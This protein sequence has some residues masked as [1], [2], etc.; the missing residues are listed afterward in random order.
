[1]NTLYLVRHGENRANITKEFSHTKVDYPLT[2]KGVLQARQTAEYF[3]D[4]HVDEIYS[5]PLKRALQTAEMIAATKGL[6][7]TVI[8]SLREVNSGSLEDTPP[9]E[10]NWRIYLDTVQGWNEGRPEVALPGGENYYMLVD[11]IKQAIGEIVGDKDGKHIVV[12]GHGGIFT[13]AIGWL[14]KN[15]EADELRSAHYHNCA[16]SQIELE[17]S[18]E[19]RLEGM[20]IGWAYCDHLSGPAADLVSPIPDTPVPAERP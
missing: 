19:G 2:E 20:L 17:R 9:T 13:A 18:I 3:K 12:A 8:E 1:M 4:R 6:P 5:S 14:C 7:V 10:E 16:I 15:V 11:R